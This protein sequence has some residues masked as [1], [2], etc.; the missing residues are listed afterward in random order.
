VSDLV[1]NEG[2][3]SDD[4]ECWEC[5]HPFMTWTDEE[6]GQWVMCGCGIDILPF[7][8]ERDNDPSLIEASPKDDT[9]ED[10]ENE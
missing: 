4:D 3:A 1:T 5:H 8:E 2:W 9:D 7:F 6:G 10:N